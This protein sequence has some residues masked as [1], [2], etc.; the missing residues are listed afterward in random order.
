M[1]LDQNF[2]ATHSI[3]GMK[4]RVTEKGKVKPLLPKGLRKGEDTGFSELRYSVGYLRKANQIH[5]WMCENLDYS[6]ELGSLELENCR[7]YHISQAQAEE[8]LAIVE[9]LL[10]SKSK[11][12]AKKLLPPHDGFFF[13]S[14][15]IDD[16]Y[17]Y[18][19]EQAKSI[20]EDAILLQK[21]GWDIYYS[22]WW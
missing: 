21:H 1:G 13:G 7:N 14:D 3:R 17:W 11:R 4:V 20:L 22:G 5:G 12:Q 6:N 15:E 9:E 16:W 8:L 2:T 18:Q 10:E 19:L